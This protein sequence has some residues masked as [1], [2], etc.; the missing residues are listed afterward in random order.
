MSSTGFDRLNRFI[1]PDYAARRPFASFL[2]GIAGLQGIPLWVFYVN[3]GQAIAAFGI[4]SKDHPLMEFQPA[5]RAYQS[6]STLGFRTFLKG[7]RGGRDWYHEP[8]SPWGGQ[9]AERTM[10]IG[11]NE[12]EIQETLPRLGLRVEALYFTLPGEPFAGLVR[13]LTIRNLNDTPLTVE[14]LDGLPALMP[15]G[16]DNDGLKQLGRTIE[17]WMEVT[18][19]EQGFPLYRL[20]ASF[21]DTASVETIQAANYAVAFRGGEQLPVLVDPGVV[22]EGRT[23]LILPQPFCRSGLQAVMNAHQVTEGRTPCAFFA[24]RFELSP[25]EAT[26][27]YE[28]YGYIAHPDLLTERVQTLRSADYFEQKLAEARSLTDDLTAAVYTQSASPL[29]DAYCRQ[30]FLDNLMRGGFPLLLGGKHVYHVYSRKHGDL[31]RDYNHFVLAPEFYSQGNGNYRDIN[32]NRRNDVFF[33]PEAG[34]F[35]IRLFMSLI[36]ADGYNPLVVEGTSFYLP[37]ERAAQMLRRLGKSAVL[38][39][40]LSRSFTPGQLFAAALQADLKCAPQDFL[41]QI[42]ASAEQQ[43]EAE[44]G[45]G[46]WTDHWTYNLDLIDSFLAVF[47]D[48]KHALLFDSPPL[49]FFDNAVYVRP[50]RERFVLTEEGPRQLNAVEHDARKAALIAS[51]SRD[52]HWART[53]HGRGQVFRLP[54]FSKLVLLALL[55]FSALDPSGYGVQM[56]AGRPGWYDAL[57]GLPALFGSSMPE[58]FE[59]LRLLD[60]LSQALIETP[61][62]VELP[63]EALG[64]LGA[65]RAVLEQD[66]AP[67]RAWQ[68]LSTAL[69]TYRAAVHWG[70]DGATEKVHLVRDL[71]RMRLRLQSGIDRALAVCDGVPPTYF[72]HAVRDYALTGKTDSHGRPLLR[73]TA[74]EARA[75]P[76]FLEGPVRWMKIAQAQEVGRLHDRLRAGELFDRQLGMY[77]V[78]ASLADWPHSI[79]RAR[80]FPPGWLENESIWLH[81]AFKYLLGLLRAGLYD[82]FFAGLKKGLPAFMDPAIYGRSPLENS[83]FIV[84]SAHPD[85]S[86]HGNG[87]VA[88]LSGSTAEFLSMWVMMT[89]GPQPFRLEDNRLVMDLRPALPGWLFRDDGRFSFRFL[90]KVDITYHNPSRR[91]TFGGL[92]MRQ[93]VV[94]LRD[95]QSLTFPGGTV[96]APY[97]QMVRTGQVLSIEA[98]FDA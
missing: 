72:I 34:E 93:V 62:P 98:Y 53:E 67:M 24:S 5:N 22:F 54:L 87:F 80:A 63:V 60:F 46:F 27:F 96:P 4:E 1:L 58:T 47:P 29:F 77:R 43:V 91:D 56:E 86:L 38:E 31:E 70:F 28:L 11:L 84:S 7:R 26:T 15:W 35:N 10:F 75:L 82:E 76:L 89:V 92:R 88:R 78:N 42:L 61:R 21:R 30:T 16:V 71:E 50:R 95:G 73:V 41:E 94:R 20:K 36:Q 69:E 2:P 25:R 85:E 17:A 33:L 57:N 40:L 8:F 97:A 44:H 13:R 32:Q 9:D 3:R 23:D 81:M 14:A 59:L 51:R 48:Q 64:L 45:E 83:S 74:F 66:A 37:P 79:G 68:R 49:P 6:T 39:N 55:K 18:G 65:I 52:A 19:H 90:G 12:V